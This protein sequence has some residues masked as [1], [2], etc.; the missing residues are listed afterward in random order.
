MV[1]LY[2]KNYL[3]LN[4][5]SPESAL[6][7]AA[8]LMQAQTQPTVRLIRLRDGSDV[9]APDYTLYI[10][11]LAIASF[12]VGA[13][14]IPNDD[15]ES[16]FE[17]VSRPQ[18]IAIAERL[19]EALS[20]TLQEETLEQSDAMAYVDS[21][22]RNPTNLIEISDWKEAKYGDLYEQGNLIELVPGL[23]GYVAAE[24]PPY[25][26][27]PAKLLILP[28]Y[29]TSEE[30]IGNLMNHPDVLFTMAFYAS[31]FN[32]G[33][34]LNPSQL[35]EATEIAQHKINFIVAEALEQFNRDCLQTDTKLG[36][37]K[38]GTEISYL[39]RARNINKM[40]ERL[41]RDSDIFYVLTLDEDMFTSELCRAG[42]LRTPNNINKVLEAAKSRVHEIMNAALEATYE[43]FAAVTKCI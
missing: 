6:S 1:Q 3:Q 27:D 14:D 13:S 41:E 36:L 30:V 17:N 19:A 12:I 16:L 26:N 43:T 4:M 31:D 37:E 28:P 38:T 20:A 42:Y 24:E 33:F 11:N 5:K 2:Y 34:N 23:G 9:G 32:Q 21:A 7:G 10:N 35:K 15:D 39:G 18:I 29:E 22:R 8:R 40:R 25:A